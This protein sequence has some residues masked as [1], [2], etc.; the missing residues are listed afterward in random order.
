MA[1]P[2]TIP[3]EA[4]P[5]ATMPPL[6]R[7]GHENRRRGSPWTRLRWGSPGLLGPPPARAPLRPLGPPRGVDMT[8]RRARHAAGPG[9]LLVGDAAA[10]VDPVA[11]QGVLRALASGIMTGCCSS[12]LQTAFRPPPRRVA[13][14][15]PKG[16]SPRVRPGWIT[17]VRRTSHGYLQGIQ[18]PE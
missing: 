8:W 7:R 1:E 13:V 14:R 2:R 11:A 17:A 4:F 15:Y 6:L 12:G 5:Q 10:V 3:P 9:W 16:S 18:A